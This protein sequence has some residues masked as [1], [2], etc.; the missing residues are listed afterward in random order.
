YAYAKQALQPGMQVK[1]GIGG[2][3]VFGLIRESDAGVKQGH[4]PIGLLDCDRGE[5][6]PRILRKMAPEEPILWSDVE[7]G[8]TELLR[9]YR[10]QEKLT[11]NIQ[12][13][14]AV[15]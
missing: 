6:K 13:T 2:D 5:P 10:A 1:H 7:L 3:D 12:R 15:S 8:D 4:L 9:I 14:E 11:T